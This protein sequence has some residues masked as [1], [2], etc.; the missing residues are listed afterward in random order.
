[1]PQFDYRTAALGCAAGTGPTAS[2]TPSQV[3]TFNVTVTGT[4]AAGG[5]ANLTTSV[6]VNDN[7]WVS[8]VVASPVAVDVGQPFMVNITIGG[9]TPPFVWSFTG[10]PINCGKP[11]EMA[12]NCTPLVAGEI[13]LKVSVTDHL[14][15]HNSSEAVVVEVHP[16][17]RIIS[18]ASSTPSEL[19]LGSST[20]FFV[21]LTGGTGAFRYAYLGLPPGCASPG[22]GNWICT[23]TAIGSYQV[24]VNATDLVGRSTTASTWLNVTHPA[25]QSSGGSWT[26]GTG[27]L[28][29]LVGAI[30]GVIAGLA[31][32][33]VVGRRRRPPSEGPAESPPPTAVVTERQP[34]DEG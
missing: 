18:F 24:S 5:Q 8:Q 22:G 3:G 32:A 28:S 21:N 27:L 1:L 14:G 25:A 30:A 12:F 33:T 17:P 19:V 10:L 9:G 2:C 23:P 4:D 29:I 31:I 7:P 13:D 20:T 6:T 16:D 11:S 15:R 34:W 26:S